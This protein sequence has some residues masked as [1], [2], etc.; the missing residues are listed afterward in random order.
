MSESLHRPSSVKLRVPG[1]LAVAPS[2]RWPLQFHGQVSQPV[3]MA[4]G[5]VPNHRSLEV[6]KDELGECRAGL[7][8]SL[9]G[10]AKKAEYSGE[11]GD[12]GF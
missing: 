6:F 3:G 5:S 7:Q 12:W 4:E 2:S 11:V 10:D 8:R 9:E 1:G